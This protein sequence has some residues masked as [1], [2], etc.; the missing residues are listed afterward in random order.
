MIQTARAILTELLSN[1]GEEANVT[2]K[3]HGRPLILESL[4]GHQTLLVSRKMLAPKS[5]FTKFRQ[6]CRI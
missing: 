3:G 4:E 6:C 1:F 2:M 5:H